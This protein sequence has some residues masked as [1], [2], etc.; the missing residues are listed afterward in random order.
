[1]QFPG[2]AVGGERGDQRQLAAD[3]IRADQPDPAGQRRGRDRLGA[4]GKPRQRG[5]TAAGLGP[6]LHTIFGLLTVTGRADAD[7]TKVTSTSGGSLPVYFG[8]AR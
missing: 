1:M 7:R 5:P 2:P 4:A 6:A 3:L 8:F